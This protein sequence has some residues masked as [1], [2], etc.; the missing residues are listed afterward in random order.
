MVEPEVEVSPDVIAS[1]DQPQRDELGRWLPGQTGNPLGRPPR[2]TEQQYLDVM[3]AVC[4]PD[5][6]RAITAKAVEQAKRGDWHARKW[7]SDYLL[8]PAIQRLQVE[9]SGDRYAAY[10]AILTGEGEG[11]EGSTVELPGAG[12]DGPGGGTVAVDGK[13]VG[14][15]D[16]IEWKSGS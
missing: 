11:I 10:L 1:G 2:A 4:T 16:H 8:G 3:L 9:G 5:A 12:V 6:W 13:V 15:S 7:L 14:A